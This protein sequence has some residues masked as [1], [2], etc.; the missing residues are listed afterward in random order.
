MLPRSVEPTQ[1][2]TSSEQP[3]MMYTNDNDLNM[4][5][6]EQVMDG[7]QNWYGTHWPE[8]N[9]WLTTQMTEQDPWTI[10]SETRFYYGPE[11]NHQQFYQ[12]DYSGN[13]DV[14]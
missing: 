3:L 7:N 8:P 11:M 1:Q 14:V 4:D 9:N 5:Y 13:M 10:P 2:E 6:P 12:S